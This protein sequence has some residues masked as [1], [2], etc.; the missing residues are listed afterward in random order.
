MDEEK[1]FDLRT[2]KARLS[3][4]LQKRQYKELRESTS[5]M[6]PADLAALMIWLDKK[7]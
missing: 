1:G 2:E 7:A 3:E 4:L 5:D 6:H